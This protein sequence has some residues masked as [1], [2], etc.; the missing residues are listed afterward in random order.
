MWCQLRYRVIIAIA[1]SSV[2]TGVVW[3]K[4]VL[5]D[6]GGRRILLICCVVVVCIFFMHHETSASLLPL[7]QLHA[8][9]A[10]HLLVLQCESRAVE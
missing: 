10:D 8:E 7:D 1:N 6:T 3:T 4:P 9:T 2:S 5:Q